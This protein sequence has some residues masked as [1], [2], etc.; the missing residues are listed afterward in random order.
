MRALIWVLWLLLVGVMGVLA[1]WTFSWDGDAIRFRV[2]G[3]L[4]LAWMGL[5]VFTRLPWKLPPNR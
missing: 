4:M 2:V 5:S 1:Y 3:V